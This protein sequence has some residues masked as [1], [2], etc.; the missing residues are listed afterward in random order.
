MLTRKASLRL[1]AIIICFAGV[2]GMAMACGDQDRNQD[3][4]GVGGKKGE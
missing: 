3:H 1:L 2:L 4:Q